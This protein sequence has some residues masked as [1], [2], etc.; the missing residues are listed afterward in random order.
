M[1]ELRDKLTARVPAKLFRAFVEQ[2]ALE[3]AVVRDGN[4]LRLPEHRLRSGPTNSVW[5]ARS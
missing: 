5:S 1:E 4:L 3:K 2:L